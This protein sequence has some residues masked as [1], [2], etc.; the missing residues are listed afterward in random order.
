MLKGQT[1]QT[2]VHVNTTYIHSF[3]YHENYDSH[4]TSP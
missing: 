1:Q 2:G 4:K 3:R